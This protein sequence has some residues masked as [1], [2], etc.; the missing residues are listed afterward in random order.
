MNQKILVIYYLLISLILFFL[1]IILNF[2]NPIINKTNEIDR[3]IVVIFFI[4]ICILGFSLS[5]FPRWY[6]KIIKNKKKY[7][8]KSKS[9][10]KI[11]KR[12]GHHPNCIKFKNHIIKIEDKNFCSGCFGLGIGSIISIVIIIY[13]LIFNNNQYLAIY[14]YSFFLG[15]LIIIL[16]YI[17]SILN[18]KKSIIHIL[19]NIFLIIGFFL[20][21]ISTLENSGSLVYGL[22]SIISS[23][24]F[25]ETRIQI[26]MLNHIN[27]CS[28]CNEQ[29]KMY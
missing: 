17:E 26:S 14:Q 23:F 18:N 9:D 13:Y 8:I 11:R 19:S 29:C 16:S 1:L 21:I 5:F 6:K 4:L 25:L 28:E 12:E 3:I 2:F 22:I 27:I 15:V 24:L 20:I 7:L 10:K